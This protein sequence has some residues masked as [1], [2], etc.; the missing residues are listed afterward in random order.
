MRISSF[1]FLCDTFK[2]EKNKS[3]KKE[4]LK[5][6]RKEGAKEGGREGEKRNVNKIRVVSGEMG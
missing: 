4:K 6:R 1:N 5:E 2:A 3:E